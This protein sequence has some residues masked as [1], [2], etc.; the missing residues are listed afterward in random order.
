MSTFT[1]AMWM[2]IRDGFESSKRTPTSNTTSNTSVPPYAS[3]TYAFNGDVIM[4]LDRQE[5]VTHVSSSGPTHRPLF[6]VGVGV[7][8]LLMLIIMYIVQRGTTLTSDTWIKMG[9]KYVPCM[10]ALTY[11]AERDMYNSGLKSQCHAFLFPYQIYRFFTPM[12]LH[13]GVTHLLNN[14]VYQALAGSLLERKYGTKTFAISYIL[15]G[16]SGNIMSA[17]IRPKTVSVGASGAVYGLLF[18]CIIDNTLRI[19][20]IKNLQDKIIQFL[21]MLLVI[22]YFV[23]S[24]FLDVDFSGRIDH[25][26]HGG[27][28]LMGILVALFLCEMPEFITKRVPNGARRIQFVALVAIVGYFCISLL[29]FYI[30]PIRMK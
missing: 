19:F 16:F 27:G 7:F 24:V 21:I 22:P 17:L 1:R 18:F 9:G 8:D 26:A 12:F 10:K 29:V 5:R 20:T 23:M 14:L 13:G 28:A 3:R 15:F 6:T 30:K 4:E 11:K 25:A 2:K